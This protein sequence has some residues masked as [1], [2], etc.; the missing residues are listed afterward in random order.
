MLESSEREEEDRQR[1]ERE[2]QLKAEISAEVAPY[3]GGCNIAHEAL[4]RSLAQRELN[5]TPSFSSPLSMR[6][7]ELATAMPW[8]QSAPDAVL[9]VHARQQGA[10]AEDGVKRTCHVCNG[11]IAPDARTQLGRLGLA[12]S[13]CLRAKNVHAPKTNEYNGLARQNG[14]SQ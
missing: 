14:K 13:E 11:D 12:H 1:A 7:P 3:T 10:Q 5:G 9:P 4:V 8:G 6:R 2:V